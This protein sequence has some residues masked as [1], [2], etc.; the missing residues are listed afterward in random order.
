MS[1]NCQNCGLEIEIQ[2]FKG[3]DFCSDN[4]RKELAE[5]SRRN[6]EALDLLRKRLSE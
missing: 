4:C 2:I 1:G 5:Q 6:A 3:E